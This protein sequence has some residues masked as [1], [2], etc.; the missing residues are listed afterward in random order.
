MN[1]DRA[2]YE[3]FKSHSAQIMTYHASI[4]TPEKYGNE[5]Y[6]QLVAMGIDKASAKSI[7]LEKSNFI[8]N[9]FLMGDA[10]SWVKLELSR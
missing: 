10:P 3:S 4:D 5:V 6:R 2:Q 7:C 1:Y 8:F 9:S